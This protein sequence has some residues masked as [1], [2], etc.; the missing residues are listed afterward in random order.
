MRNIN[1]TTQTPHYLYLSSQTINAK[2]PYTHFMHSYSI[3]LH[4]A[5]LSIKRCDSIYVV[6]WLR[7]DKIAYIL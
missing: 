4:S 5:R 7:E 1:F 6:F 3:G 2:A